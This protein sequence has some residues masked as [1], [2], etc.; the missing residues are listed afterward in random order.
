MMVIFK[1]NV[2]CND[3]ATMNIDTVGARQITADGANIIAGDIQPDVP[4]MLIYTGSSFELISAF[5]FRKIVAVGAAIEAETPTDDTTF[6]H[7]AITPIPMSVEIWDAAGYHSGANPSRLT[8]PTDLGGLYLYS[9]RFEYDPVSTMYGTVSAFIRKGGSGEN[10]DT[11]F[12][13]L[14]Y[15]TDG[16]PGVMEGTGIIVLDDAEYIE[17]CF[18]N[19]HPTIDCTLHFTNDKAAQLSL[20]RLGD[21]P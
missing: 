4:Y 2:A 6:T 3:D 8:I 20:V 17:I 19:Q 18:K 13:G 12:T 21:A 14:I 7:N 9:G 15:N 5:L 1:G 16:R 10:Q 11:R